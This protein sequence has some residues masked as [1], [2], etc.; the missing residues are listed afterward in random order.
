MSNLNRDNVESLEKLAAQQIAE[1]VDR[2][3]LHSWEGTPGGHEVI[4]QAS[5]RLED[6]RNGEPNVGSWL[7][8]KEDNQLFRIITRRMITE[9]YEEHSWAN[10]CSWT[11]T[12][13]VPLFDIESIEP[14]TNPNNPE[15][16]AKLRINNVKWDVGFVWYLGG[17]NL[18]D[19]D[20]KS[21]QF[22][23]MDFEGANFERADLRGEMIERCNFEGANFQ[24]ADLRGANLY[25]CIFKNANFKFVD[26]RFKHNERQA[27][28]Y[29]TTL[30]ECDFEGADVTGTLYSAHTNFG[31]K[32]TAMKDQKLNKDVMVL[33][34][35]HEE[36]NL[37][38]TLK[39]QQN[40]YKTRYTQKLKIKW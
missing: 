31:W 29:E 18:R 16:S 28:G 15:E 20:L 32:K 26:L 33:T 38:A 9:E 8:R 21:I 6:I 3:N 10:R 12:R 14:I 23:D 2:H 36:R 27:P 22:R 39:S 7:K 37:D 17:I 11:S 35:S 1:H 34:T 24:G 40:V 30:R 4:H 5:L 19:V 13:Q 25:K